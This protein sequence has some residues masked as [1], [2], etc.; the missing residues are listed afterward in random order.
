MQSY[1]SEL[2]FVCRCLY[3]KIIWRVR[4]SLV[5]L[6]LHVRWEV[7]QLWTWEQ[8]CCTSKLELSDYRCM[9]SFLCLTWMSSQVIFFLAQDQWSSDAFH[10]LRIIWHHVV[11]AILAKGWIINLRWFLAGNFVISTK[12]PPK[13]VVRCFESVKEQRVAFSS[14]SVMGWS[15]RQS[16]IDV[17]AGT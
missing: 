1:V 4:L 2:I 9:S 16:K 3:H 13:S 5:R 12:I 11:K 7:S 15:Q 17:F 10:F 14:A 6:E 8:N